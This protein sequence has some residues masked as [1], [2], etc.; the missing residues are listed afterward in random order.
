MA[1]APHGGLDGDA[2]L[3][4]DKYLEGRMEAAKMSHKYD[5]IARKWRKACRT[6][7]KVLLSHSTNSTFIGRG[8][9]SVSPFLFLAPML[10]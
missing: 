2:R 5:K 8:C 10:L 3:S 6:L 7:R 9:P 4:M 1:P